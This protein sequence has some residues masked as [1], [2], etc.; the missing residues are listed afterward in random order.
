MRSES[1]ADAM[2]GGAHLWKGRAMPLTSAELIEQV[3][4]A[5]RVIFAPRPFPLAT[6]EVKTFFGDLGRSLDFRI[7]ASGYKGADDGEWL[8]DLVWFESDEEG[9]MIRQALVLQTEGRPDLVL[10]GD[11]QKLV[12]AR[13]DLRVWITSLPNAVL[14][15]QHVETCKRQ[16][17]LFS[18]RSVGDI[19]LLIVYDWAAKLSLIERFAVV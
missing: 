19:Y 2:I 6:R 5:A 7:C 10:D 18:G 15:R 3:E 14:S 11:F 17:Q 1:K 16:A 8:Y 9:F 4:A 12:Q 13:A